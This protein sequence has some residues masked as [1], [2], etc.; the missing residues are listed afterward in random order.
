[1]REISTYPWSG[2]IRIE[3]EPEKPAKFTLKLR[4]PGWAR[5]ATASVNGKPVAVAA[6]TENG[7]LAISRQW[8]PGD[9]VALDLPMPAERI[10]AHPAVRMDAGRVALK[11]GPLVYCVEEVDNPRGPVQRLKLPRGSEIKVDAARRPVRRR[12]HAHRRCGRDST[13]AT[14][15]T[16]SIAP[17]RRP[18]GPRR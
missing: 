18:S 5:D 9:V 2:D 13:T 15:A 4:I 8:G 12:R 6:A 7:Y 1:M 11:R 3:V 16:G 10:Y 17:S 14:G